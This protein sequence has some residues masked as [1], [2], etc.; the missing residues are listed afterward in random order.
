MTAAPR[1]DLAPTSL[2]S[3]D[4][5]VIG[6][7]IAGCCA[8][9]EAARAGTSV[10]V[11]C[12]GRLCSGSSFFPGTWGLGLI[13]PI[14]DAD[15]DDLTQTILQVGCGVADPD[16]VHTLVAGI[17]PGMA[18]LEE[19]G[20][21]LA[22]PTSAESAQER[23][24]IPCF[25]HKTRLWRGLTR[26]STEEAFRRELSRQGVTVHAG[27]ELV[28]LVGLG[29]AGAADSDAGPNRIAGAIL[30]D[31]AAQR[32]VC[33]PA[34]AVVVATGG[35]GGLFER[36]LT[37]RDVL[38]STQGIAL[39]HGCALVN[40]EFMQ[41]MPGLVA[42]RA[43]LVFNEKSFR[44]VRCS[45]QLDQDLLELRSGY[46]PFTCR[47]A[48][49]AVDL[50]IDA[51]GPQGLPVRYRFPRID[52]PEFMRTFCAWL[53]REHGIAPDDELRIAMYAHAANGGIRI[54]RDGRSGAPGL[55]AAGEATGGMHG[56]DRIGGL[57]SANGLVF[58]RRAG[59]AAARWAGDAD[60]IPA[61][62]I[63]AK[64]WMEHVGAAAGALDA[65]EAQAATR[66]LRHLMSTRCMIDRA[67]QGLAM[68][69]RG[70]DDLARDLADAAPAPARIAPIDADQARW[71]RLSS[72]IALA[73]A[74]VDSMRARTESLG[75]HYRADFPPAP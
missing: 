33:A 11:A 40:I 73:R 60:D 12:A 58:G 28:D 27:A 17:R 16:L 54:D 46:G 68:A 74:M 38:S 57:S 31:R 48:S 8:A 75:S 19:L 42:P 13:G 43:G 25:D 3:V 72:Q 10:A 56:A 63:L 32:L 41:M 29:N 36:S 51:A 18:W 52:V 69:R 71:L 15:A 22:R 5:L 6:S 45:P 50:A 62:P 53:E 35:T 37:S 47:L 20:V 65:E 1:P 4:V 61:G 66:T 39:A 30:Y 9:I 49:R 34:H 7:G 21:D 67:E 59:A 64:D 2:D 55:F 24:F 23:A 70:L 26:H 14:D 44:Y